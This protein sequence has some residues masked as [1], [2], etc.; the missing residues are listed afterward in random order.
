M[1]VS[2]AWNGTEWSQPQT[3]NDDGTADFHPQ[4]LLS[5]D[6]AML[7]AWEDQKIVLN[8]SD[9]FET[10]VANMEIS[11][12]RYNPGSGQ[13]EGA[14]RLTDNNYLDRSPAIS[15][16]GGQ[17]D[18]ALLTWI[19]NESN[20]LIGSSA[21]PNTLRFSRFDG[22]TWAT[23]DTAI[24][25]PYPLIKYDTIFES[26]SGKG[27]VVMSLDID[28]DLSTI[29]DRQLFTLTY[30]NGSWGSLT[31]LTTDDL[32]DDNPQLALDPSGNVVLVWL[33]DSELSSLSATSF[34]LPEMTER[35]IILSDESGYSN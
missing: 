14:Q 19:S 27:L 2:S 5:A 13:W 35:Q 1:A 24:E 32:P 7:C 22:Q 10:M 16:S 15:G 12:A 29:A 33:K 3:I 25:I 11:V 17:N 6:D 8:D 9:D 26:S 23:P 4:L 18:E 21:T 20:D 34:T 28:D 31:Q 30:Q